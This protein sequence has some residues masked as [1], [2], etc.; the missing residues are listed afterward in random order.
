PEILLCDEPTGNLDEKTSQDIV[1]LLADLNRGGQ[2]M[3][4]VTHE[5]ELASVAHRTVEIS[6]GRIKEGG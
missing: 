3:V 6:G 5:R 2:T 1:T 4:V